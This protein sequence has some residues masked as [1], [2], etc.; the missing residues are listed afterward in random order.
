MG[1]KWTDSFFC[2]TSVKPPLCPITL[3]TLLYHLLYNDVVTKAGSPPQVLLVSL[4]CL[5]LQRRQR[6]WWKCVTVSTSWSWNLIMVWPDFKSKQSAAA[7]AHVTVWFLLPPL[8]F[9]CT[10][11][12]TLTDTLT[13][14]LMT[15]SAHPKLPVLVNSC[16]SRSWTKIQHSVLTLFLGFVPVPV[17][18][19][20]VSD[21]ECTCMWFILYCTK[22]AVYNSHLIIHY[23]NGMFNCQ[24]SNIFV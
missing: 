12:H 20:G 24:V 15:H 2:Q 7:S 16:G 11:T 18:C 4:L 8:L 6:Q 9:L 5:E 19:T 1:F 14:T 17:L 21:V 3:N 13:H 22:H 23:Y 10:L